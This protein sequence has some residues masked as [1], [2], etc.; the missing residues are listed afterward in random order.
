MVH[1]TPAGLAPPEFTRE[2]FMPTAPPGTVLPE[3][4]ETVTCCA[5]AWLAAA[6]TNM[7][8]YLNALV[9]DLKDELAI[10]TQTLGTITEYRVSKST[11]FLKQ[12]AEY[13]PRANAEIGTLRCY[14]CSER[15]DKEGVDNRV[16][17][18]E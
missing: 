15:R 8:A 14:D 11:R 4:Q 12:R 13:G 7:Q 6:A 18:D 16:K 5:T 2:I 17:L 1:C 9:A 10:I 3:P